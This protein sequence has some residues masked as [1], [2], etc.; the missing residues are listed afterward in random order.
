MIIYYGC[1]I[2]YIVNKEGIIIDLRLNLLKI[3]FKWN[4]LI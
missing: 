4:I 3:I 1:K 2:I